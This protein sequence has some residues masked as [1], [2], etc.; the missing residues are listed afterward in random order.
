MIK[1][2]SFRFEFHH[3]IECA[4]DFNRKYELIFILDNLYNEK[5]KKLQE[6]RKINLNVQ[7]SE[8]LLQQRQGISPLSLFR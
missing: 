6:F 2:I 7:K 4:E 1:N 5:M 3:K 8:Q